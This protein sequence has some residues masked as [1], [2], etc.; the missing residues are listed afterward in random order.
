MVFVRVWVLQRL[1]GVSKEPHP[2]AM[3]PEYLDLLDKS[4]HNTVKSPF[5]Y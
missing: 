3:V 2:G 5:T 1:E 4:S